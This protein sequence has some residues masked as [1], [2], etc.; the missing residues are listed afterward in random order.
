[1]AAYQELYQTGELAER[2]EQVRATLQ[3]C[4]LCP[5][6]CRI[7][8]LQ[9]ETG[10]CRTASEAVVSSYGPHHGEEAPLVGL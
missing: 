5:R 1:M 6:R 3:N 7:N 10:T 9:G 4:E 2:I 8:R